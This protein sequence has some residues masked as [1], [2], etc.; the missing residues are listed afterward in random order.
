[1][2][3]KCAAPKCTSGYVSNEK[4]QIAKIHFPLKKC[5]VTEVVDSFCQ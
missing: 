5:G 2:F 1:M 3:N 4:K